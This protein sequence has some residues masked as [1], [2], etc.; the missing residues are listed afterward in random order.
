MKIINGLFIHYTC[1]NRGRNEHYEIRFAS[2][3][4]EGFPILRH[5]ISRDPQ[6]D[7]YKFA[8]E[9]CKAYKHTAKS[10][11]R[12]RHLRTSLELSMVD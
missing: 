2:E 4:R 6:I 8:V 9:F 10:V 7:D 5:K 11:A 1:S 12:G 3:G